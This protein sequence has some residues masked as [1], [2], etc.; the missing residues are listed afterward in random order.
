MSS[1]GFQINRALSQTGF[2]RRKRSRYAMKVSCY[3]DRKLPNNRSL[4]LV[5]RASDREKRDVQNNIALMCTPVYPKTCIEKMCRNRMRQRLF[6]S[7]ELTKT[8]INIPLTIRSRQFGDTSNVLNAT[9]A[10][11]SNK[12]KHTR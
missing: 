9:F 10:E 5:Y 12:S 1:N 4:S 2:V 11:I 8:V 7:I 3:A 6:E